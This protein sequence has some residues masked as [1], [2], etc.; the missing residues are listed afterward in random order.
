MERDTVYSDDPVKMAVKWAEAGARRLHLVD[1]D[2]A[3]EGSPI[4]HHVIHQIAEELPTI[5]IQVGG[6]IRDEDTIQSYLDAGVRYVILGT[7]AVTAP[8]FVSDVCIEFPGHIM[9]GLDVRNGKV[10]I[11]GWSKLSKHD[12]LD[13]A[14]R[15]ESDGVEAIIYTD[16]GR[17][18][19]MEGLNVEATASLARELKIPVYASG[20]VTNLED[21]RRLSRVSKDGVSGA[22]TGKALYEG[23]LDFSEAQALADQ[24]SDS[25]SV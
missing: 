24:L 11:D 23:K 2:G 15:F 18:G 20:G 22:I 21:I 10:A 3:F 6:G 16:I 5:D 4:N 8:H 17:D 9:V 12:A 1:L 13:I 14:Q 25:N 19:M 7:K